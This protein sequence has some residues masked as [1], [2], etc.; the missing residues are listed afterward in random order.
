MA[1]AALKTQ[2]D[3]LFEGETPILFDEWQESRQ[4]G[5]T[6]V[7]TSTIYVATGS[8]SSPGRRP[9]ADAG[10]A[11]GCRSYWHLHMRPMSLYESG[12]STGEVSLAALLHGEDQ[13][14][15]MT[16]MTVPGLME[17]IVIGGWPEMIDDRASR[18]RLAGRLPPQI[19]EIDIPS[20]G[21]TRRAPPDFATPSPRWGDRSG[22][23]EA[24]CTRSGIAGGDNQ[25]P[26][27][28]T[29]NTYLDAL[30]RLKLI[31][32]SAAWQPHIRSRARLRETPSR[33]FV[34]PSLGIAALGVGSAI[35]SGILRRPASTS[36]RLSFVT[37]AST[38]SRWAA[39]FSTWR[40]TQAAKRST[41]SRDAGRHG[42]P[43]R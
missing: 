26:A 13:R 1:Q 3:G 22:G 4:L 14:A 35:C 15:G 42:P 43:S 9:R 24:H 41:P 30:D 36:R 23:D 12:H 37:F 5:I 31:D 34:D 32:N 2:P 28:E 19:V 18:A 38:P 33:Y 40:E 10:A 39:R 20:L 25:A 6:S 8:T 17:R 16:T 27:R 29:V 11:L 7:G 21:T